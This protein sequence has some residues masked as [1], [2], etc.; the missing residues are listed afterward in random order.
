[1]DVL[2]FCLPCICNCRCWVVVC[3]IDCNCY[4]SFFLSSCIL[5]L[6]ISIC[7]VRTVSLINCF[8]SK[9]FLLSKCPNLPFVPPELRGRLSK[10]NTNTQ[11]RELET[12]FFIAWQL[13]QI[14]NVSYYL[15]V[16]GN[17]SLCF[18]QAFMR[19]PFG[20]SPNLV[21][22]PPATPEDNDWGSVQFFKGNILLYTL[23]L[24]CTTHFD[25]QFQHN[26][27][28]LTHLIECKSFV[29]ERGRGILDLDLD[30]PTFWT[31]F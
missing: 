12:E 28:I 19:L 10:G 6:T 24:H 16:I 1:M 30:M 14:T 20:R 4:N 3:L 11:W 27:C 23:C 21:Y 25:H 15:K 13:F 7:S 9:S 2:Y 29:L 22:A 31:R 17:D 5:Y 8:R 26:R 18:W